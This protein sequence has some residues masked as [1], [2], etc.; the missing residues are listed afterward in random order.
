MANKI[1]KG[2]VSFNIQ[3]QIDIKLGRIKEK[4]KGKN[5][6]V[7]IVLNSFTIQNDAQAN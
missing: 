4:T 3:E 6:D 2:K 7:S 5:Q 1:R